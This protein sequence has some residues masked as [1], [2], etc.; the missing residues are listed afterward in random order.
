MKMAKNH[1]IIYVQVSTSCSDASDEVHK[2]KALCVLRVHPFIRKVSLLQGYI[3]VYT[4]YT[5]RVTGF[6]VNMGIFGYC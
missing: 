3:Y 2:M 6:T 4:L 1:Q 5:F